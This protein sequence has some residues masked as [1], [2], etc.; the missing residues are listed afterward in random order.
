[1]R[2]DSFFKQ[3]LL[4]ERLLNGITSIEPSMRAI[5]DKVCLWSATRYFWSE[6]FWFAKKKVRRILIKITF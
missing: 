4:F 3:Y 2:R 6:F 5:F 1:M